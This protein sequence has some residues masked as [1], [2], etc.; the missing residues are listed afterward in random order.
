MT[1]KQ[2]A[3]LQITSTIKDYSERLRIDEAMTNR[4]KWGLVLWVVG[5]F[6]ALV[7]GLVWIF[8]KQ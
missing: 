6:A 8:I 1:I 3:S 7:A 2:R 5:L 4:E